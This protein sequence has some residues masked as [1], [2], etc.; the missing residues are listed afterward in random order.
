MTAHILALASPKGGA[1]KT[2]TSASMGVLLSSLGKRVLL[3][4]TDGATNGMSLMYLS[5]IVHFKSRS[6]AIGLYDLARSDIGSSLASRVKI[7]TDLDFV[8]ATF[9]M[10]QTDGVDV[11]AFAH[12]LQHTLTAVEESY[13]YIL[14]D[15][16]AGTDLYAR[17]AIECARTVVIVS[18]Y[19]PVSQEGVV[20]LR[21]VFADQL[22]GRDVWVL[23]NKILPEFAEALGD[24]LLPLRYL[25]PIPWDADVVRSFAQRRLALDMVNGNVFT[26]VLLDVVRVL[27]NGEL[28][29]EIDNW[30]RSRH[31][32]L[33]TPAAE[34]LTAVEKELEAT[35]TAFVEAQ[36][37][38]KQL[39]RSPA[40]IVLGAATAVVAACMALLSMAVPT[41]VG[42]AYRLDVRNA[43]LGGVI[44]VTVAGSLVVMFVREARRS[45][46]TK[47]RVAIQRQVMALEAQIEDLRSVA[48]KYRASINASG[49]LISATTDPLSDSIW[50]RR[51]GVKGDATL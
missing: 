49:T 45:L 50:A 26:G 14:L 34:R 33:R 8:P 28:D 35:E 18:E 9:A 51:I 15:A 39:D 22:E 47:R 31:A 37:R 27:S 42:P 5:R 3:I 11:T 10:S 24:T 4:D 48:A 19:D 16:Q 6:D 40:L 29:G 38:L 21:H 12:A 44:G 46:S 32:A 17:S 1:G 43:L 2:I 41:A 13:D 30:C 23:V 20:R 25:P 36:I 7:E